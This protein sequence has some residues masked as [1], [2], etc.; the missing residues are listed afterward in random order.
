MWLPEKR[1]LLPGD[2]FYRAFPN[3][4]TIRGTLYRDVLQ[5]VESLDRMRERR[6]EHLVPSHTRPLSGA[7]AIHAAL[8]D[9]RD[10]I[11]FVHDQTIRGINRGLTPDEIAGSLEL[12]EHLRQSPFLQPFYGTVEW[13]SR[14]VFTGYLGWFDGNAAHLAPLSRSEQAARMAALASGGST[15]LDAARAALDADDARWAAQLADHAV[16]LDPQDAE[17][18]A[19]LASALRRLGETHPSANGRH[20][21]LTQA[22]EAAGDLAVED[23]D[24]SQFPVELIHGF[25]L[26]GILRAMSVNLDPE[27]SA[28]VDTVVGFRFPDVG[29]SWTVHV[30]RG[31]AEIQPRFPDEPDVSVTVNS[32]VWKELLAGLRNPA[33]TL[34]SDDIEVEGG[35]L[36]LVS[37]LA[38]FRPE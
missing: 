37:F 34:A 25:P 15:L 3:L 33:L 20:Y 6:P 22:L 17:A 2:N 7:D 23:P 21:Y 38:L 31:V 12:P 27:K 36:A 4:Y 13:S 30:R 35:R 26:S 10:A 32:T 5:W 29:E 16:A 9:Y 11:Q 14:S 19:V 24:P 1:V 18:R 28:D 8:T